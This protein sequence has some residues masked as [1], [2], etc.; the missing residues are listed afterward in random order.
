LQ[1]SR[2]L[3]R[4]IEQN[5]AIF[6]LARCRTPGSAAEVAARLRQ[7]HSMSVYTR[8]EF[9]TQTRVHWM[10]ATKAGVTAVWSAVLGLIIGIVIT[11]QTLY[12]ATAASWREYA[13]LEAL[14]IPTLRVVTTVLAQSF[15]VGAA[16]LVIAGPV[17][18]TLA[19]L[20]SLLNIRMLF[21]M[22]LLG[23]TAGVTMVT[24]ILSGLVAC[25]RCASPSRRN[26]YAEGLSM[27]AQPNC[28]EGRHLSHS[29]GQGVTRTVV[30]RQVTLWLQ[31]GEMVLVMGPSGSGKS[32][33]LALLSGLLRPERGGVMA[34]GQDLWRVSPAARKQFRQHHFGFVFQG[35]NLFPALTARQQLE[36]VLRW[37]EGLPAKSASER[38]DKMLHLLGLGGKTAL[39]PAQLSGG[40]KQRVAIGRALVKEPKFIFA[41][42][43]TGALDWEHGQ[44]VVELLR[45]AASVRRAAVFV[46]SHDS[47]I[48][49][50]AD[51]V[52][53]LEAG[54]LN[55]PE[56]AAGFARNPVI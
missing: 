28:L 3:F 2:L 55:A 12:A 11:C 16:G 31:P 35:Y 40:E 36:I 21:P 9:S 37:G 27:V 10:T 32:T 38:A 26:C 19:D 8:Q 5:Q 48:A 52:F 17:T 1:T 22:W 54:C 47:R 46:V 49:P 13:V 4:G 6:I 56:R 41:D 33:L 7:Q 24:V 53:H 45:A 44:Q 30:L 15:W 20:L 39:R 51:R 18:L 43:P 50:Y 34:L 23:P 25:G 14:G 42:E 29:F